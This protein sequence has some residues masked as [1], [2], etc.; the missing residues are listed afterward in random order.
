MLLALAAALLG[1]VVAVA[2]V[3]LAPAAQARATVRLDPDHGPAKTRVTVGGD[4]FRACLPGTA[5]VQLTWD[6]SPAGTAQVGSKGRF[7]GTVDVPANAS[8][9]AHEVTAGCTAPPSPGTPSSP[10]TPEPPDDGPV[11]SA[12]G[13]AI[14]PPPA[15]AAVTVSATAT[16][17]VE[18][19][20][21]EVT[22]T[23]ALEPASGPA[24]RQ[25][26]AEGTGFHCTKSALVVVRWDGQVVARGAPAADGSFSRPLTVPAETPPG[27]H[28][29]TASC[30]PDSPYH[31]EA[32]FTVTPPG[33]SGS[34]G[35]RDGRPELR[36]APASGRVG[37][38][39]AVTGAG[40]AC[41][42][43]EVELS[44]N[45]TTWRRVATDDGG[46]FTTTTRIAD[47]ARPGRYTL[48]AVCP[49]YPAMADDA[50]FEI[51][52]P[53]Q[54]SD[55]GAGSDPAAGGDPGADDTTPTTW[56]VGPAAGGAAVLAAAG[57][58]VLGRHRGPRWASGHVAVEPSPGEPPRPRVDET[59]DPAGPTRT[60]RLE[61]R[62]DPGTHRVEEH[63]EEE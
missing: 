15:A 35:S 4:G 57:A 62:S 45:G 27:E 9:G 38:P 48:H 58:Y 8:P 24:G 34:T 19:T 52:A 40:F 14:A 61:P 50:A 39:V 31:A 22:S 2:S 63:E 21:D 29:V 17:T 5:T 28:P 6:S 32:T 49:A 23:L 55:P 37:E 12:P 46:R 47:D 13:P 16:F 7:T 3:L 51:L 41:H 10:G 30:G 25:F 18:A 53:G 59:D 56:V 60:V 44:W 20:G 11:V 1:A 54:G 33:G 43:T 42:G 26:T 36:A